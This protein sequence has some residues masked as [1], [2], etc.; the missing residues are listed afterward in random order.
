[1]ENFEV[2]TPILNTPFDEPAAYWLIEEGRLPE[3]MRGRRPAGYYYR[4]PKAPDDDEH[5]A[6]GEWRELALV[7]LVRERMVEWRAAGRPGITRTTRELVEYW[8]RD[9]RQHR[10]FFAQR[11]AAEAIIFLN[12]ARADFLQGIAVPPD[13]RSDERQADGLKGFRRLACKMAT[14]SGKTTVMAMLAAWSILNKVNDRSDARFSDVVL[15]VCPN[16]TIRSRLGELDPRNGEASLYRTRDLVPERLMPDLTQGRVLVT[17]W[18]VFEPHGSGVGGTG[19]RVVKTGRAV[20]TAETFVVAGRTTSFRG[21]KYI[22]P[23]VLD[24]RV[25]SGEL[26]V[27]EDK[28]DKNGRRTVKVMGTAYVESDTALVNRVLKEV[29]GK[30]NILVLND[31]AHHA[32]RIQKA[33]AEEDEEQEE[34]GDNG[35]GGD[36]DYFVKEAT[37]WVDGLDRI[38]KLR[39]I[40]FCVDLSA[41]PYFIGRAGIATNTIFPWVVSDF[42]LTDAIEAGLVK[43]PQLAVRDT[44]GA[45]I[46]GYFNIWRFILPRLT[47]AERGGKK[48]N[49]KPEAVLKYAHAPIAMLGGLWDQ[50]RREWAEKD[51][52]TRPPVFILVCKNTRIARVISEWIGEDRPPTG[53]PSAGLEELR[54]K[55]GRTVTIRVDTKVVQESDDLEGA[56]SDEVAWMR[57]TLDT[58]G[59]EDWPRDS[60]QRPIY[61]DGFVELAIKLDR[62]LHPPGR[63]IR[64]IV[65][66][67]MLTEG[68]DCNTVTHIIGLRPFM[69]QLLCEQVVGRAL[70]RRSYDDFDDQGR[71][72]EEVAK[73]FGVP[74]EVIPF[75][76]N[77]AGPRPP[78]P[79]RHHVHAIPQKANYEI[80]FPRVEGYRQGIRNRV[81]VDWPSLAPLRI[82]PK[83]IPTETE[84]KDAVSIGIRPSLYGPGSSEVVTLEPFRRNQRL[85]AEVFRMAASLTREYVQRGDCQAPAHVLF[86]QLARI[87]ERYVTEKVILEPPADQLDVFL[88]PYYGRVI[89]R[90][91]EALHP[92]AANG[93]APELPILE[94]NRG[95]GSTGEVGFWTSREVREVV[96]SHVNYVV[97]DTKQWEQSATYL[98]DTHPAVDAFVKNA[99]LG[100]AIPYFH[101]GQPHDYEPDFIIRLAGGGRFLILEIKGHDEL[102]GVKEQAA[103]RW[104]A[105]VNAEG[106]HGHWQYAMVRRVGDVRGAIDAA[107]LGIAE[108]SRRQSRLVRDSETEASR[109]EDEAWAIASWETAPN[110]AG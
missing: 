56:K 39:G 5:A 45:D 34:N 69:S 18:H 72:T 41:T 97:A 42:G 63:D 24:A 76:E 86:P 75:K 55:D 104:V 96:R 105:A 95:E 36:E 79:K 11:E 108:E 4:S 81:A 49:P 6:R 109:A 102:D 54:N 70:R 25:A 73:V 83:E 32:Y 17:N 48:A 22:T 50:L 87:V 94:K 16:V 59:R 7:N 89:E 1:M 27:L 2:E 68:W 35:M 29:G 8:N 60:Q 91:T 90:L 15:V 80:R 53:I 107:R 106:R 62:P 33:N 23:A 47:P 43:I 93:E 88:S 58:V 64:C 26:H 103:N 13:Q 30:Q 77:K 21:S 65:S 67:A 40:N 31:E 99:G 28:T 85:Q 19:A 9:G 84:V 100:F 37:V 82:D 98:I 44:S 78:Q 74:F 46:A 51:D 101:N 12:E 52:E 38:N 71:L 110:D 61:P 66:V 3:R 92:D 57:L 10:L 14:G 20:A